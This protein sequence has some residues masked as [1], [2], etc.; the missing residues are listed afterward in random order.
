M[1]RFWATSPPSLLTSFVHCPLPLAHS[2]GQP[3]QTHAY[4]MQLD[5]WKNV[6]Q[7]LAEWLLRSEQMD[8][9]LGG[10]KMI[11]ENP[12]WHG[13]ASPQLLHGV[14]KA[15]CLR[16]EMRWVYVAAEAECPSKID[17]NKRIRSLNTA[18]TLSSSVLM[19]KD[20]LSCTL[21]KQTREEC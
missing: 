3:P 9:G 4:W 15:I 13:D 16:V 11:P 6:L 14:F 21:K 10:C 2:L 8:R 7:D 18:A 12:I 1:V 17:E 5:M 20:H 19:T